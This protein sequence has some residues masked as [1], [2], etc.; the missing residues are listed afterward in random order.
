MK[1][2]LL[3]LSNIFSNLSPKSTYGR[4]KCIEG[5]C[6]NGQGTYTY[7]DGGKYVGEWKDDKFHGQGTY[8]L[9]DVSKYVGEWKAGLKHGQ[10]TFTFSDGSIFVGEFK[11]NMPGQGTMT[12]A[13]GEEA[14]VEEWE[15]WERNK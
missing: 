4:G 1:K 12:H 14:F 6:E 13:D 2:F 10:G 11:A 3:F 9:P 8:T 7:P 15:I 5:D